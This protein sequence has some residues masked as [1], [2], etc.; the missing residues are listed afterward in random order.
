MSELKVFSGECC[1]CDVGIDAGHKD[2]AGKPLHTGD[3]VLVYFG[4][5]IGTDVEEWRPC[6]GLTAIVAGQY[7]SYQDGSIE[8]RS[9]TPR[10]FAMG[11]KD[12]GFDSEHWQ[13]H[14][15]KAFA[16][17]VE[18]EHWPEFGFSYRRS[19]KADAAKALNTDT[20]KR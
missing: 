4:D 18:G 17:V 15:V 20:T 2:V 10:P 12:A 8:L 19:E 14:R 3:I 7:Q 16:D 6:G 1:F 9:A 5:Y 13:I 11:I